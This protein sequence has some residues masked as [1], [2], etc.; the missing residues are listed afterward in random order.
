MAVDEPA[1]RG[2]GEIRE[3]FGRNP[4]I[5]D[6]PAQPVVRQGLPLD[7]PVELPG[8][9]PA[10]L[11]F[12]LV[13]PLQP[14]DVPLGPLPFLVY[15]AVGPISPFRLARWA[16]VRLVEQRIVV[17]GQQEAGRSEGALPSDPAA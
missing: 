12:A 3:R 1:A 13:E 8:G 10:Q 9:Q 16:A 14:V 2:R 11:L 4:V 7:D 5:E 15:D 17:R 6:V